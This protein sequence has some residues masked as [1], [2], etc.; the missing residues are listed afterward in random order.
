MSMSNKTTNI[1]IIITIK[2]IPEIDY[3]MDFLK[4]IYLTIC[5]ISSFKKNN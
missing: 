4:K 2:I 5:F 3:Q 1:K